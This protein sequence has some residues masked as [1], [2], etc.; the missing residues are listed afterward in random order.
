MASQKRIAKEFQ[1]CVTSPIDGLVVT[2]PQENDL[3]KWTV[4]LAGP[5]STPYE[6]GVFTLAVSFPPEYPFKPFSVNFSTRIYHPNVTNDDAGSICIASLKPDEY[7]P[8]KRVRDVL[9]D[10][11]D[12]L[13][14]PN[15]DDPL[16]ARIADEFVNDRSAFEKSARNYVTRYAAD[17]QRKVAATRSKTEAGSGAG[18]GSS[19]SAA[20]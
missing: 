2:L 16:E 7:K 17:P 18:S 1:I 5:P 8:N 4:T 12:L 9:S 6:G 11:R 20:K 3:T 13:V 14:K 15:P 10:V 19:R